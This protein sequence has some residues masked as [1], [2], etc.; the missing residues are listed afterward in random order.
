MSSF[1]ESRC[2]KRQFDC[3]E[4]EQRAERAERQLPF[5]DQSPAPR[6]SPEER[7]VALP[8]APGGPAACPRGSAGI[9][10][11]CRSLQRLGPGIGSPP[12]FPLP[13]LC[14]LLLIS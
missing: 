1:C 2:G 9:C 10:A 7:S 11:Q 3:S 14:L 13:A 8:G 12:S 5:I 4:A 6:Q